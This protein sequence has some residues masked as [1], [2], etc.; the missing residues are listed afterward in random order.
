MRR[1]LFGTILATFSTALPI[2]DNPGLSQLST[3]G[4]ELFTFQRTV[5]ITLGGFISI[6]ST[7][8]MTLSISLSISVR[9]R[10]SR[11]SSR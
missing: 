8:S 7:S 5:P 1:A 9:R 10:D 2:A 6:F 3:D 4:N 11:S